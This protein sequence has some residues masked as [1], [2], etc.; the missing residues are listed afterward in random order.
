VTTSGVLS[1]RREGPGLL[2]VYGGTERQRA[3]LLREIRVTGP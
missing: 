3:R 1:V 2:V